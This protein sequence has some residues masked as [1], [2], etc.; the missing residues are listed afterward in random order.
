MN[1]K[2]DMNGMWAFSSEFKGNDTIETGTSKISIKDVRL[3]MV[4]TKTD[5]I[6]RAIV[7]AFV[8]DNGKEK[9]VSGETVKLY[10][11]R[12]FSLLLI[13][14]L[15]LDNTGAASVEFPSDLPGDKEGNLTLIAK[16]EENQ[17]FGNVEKRETL[18]W[19][20]PTDY[21]VPRTHRAL[22]TKTAPKWMIYT[23]SVLLTG[24]WGHYLFAI[25]S[26]IRIKKNAKNQ[27]V[28]NKELFI[29]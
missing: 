18:K 25:I 4:L 7:K 24:V 29:K 3:E 12:M 28:E 21:S 11:P 23:L 26:L 5:S 14:E 13:S 9:P 8:Q 16:F 15:T 1:L 17:T 27:K 20:L 6:K 10:V 2:A 22:W 19:G